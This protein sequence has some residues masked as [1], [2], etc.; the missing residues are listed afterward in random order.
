MFHCKKA[1]TGRSIL[2]WLHFFLSL[3][4]PYVGMFSYLH[5]KMTLQIKRLLSVLEI[6][7]VDDQSIRQISF[8]M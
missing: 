3:I 2:L 8:V 1:D 5:V 6:P 4:F 7:L